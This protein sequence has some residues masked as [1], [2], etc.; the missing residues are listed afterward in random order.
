MIPIVFPHKLSKNYSFYIYLIK[1]HVQQNII[2]MRNKNNVFVNYMFGPWYAG[3]LVTMQTKTS[4][5]SPV[6]T[7]HHPSNQCG[8][9]G[10]VGLLWIE[11]V[12]EGG[13]GHIQ[14]WMIVWKIRYVLWN[15]GTLCLTQLKIVYRGT[16]SNIICVCLLGWGRRGL[17]C[18][19]PN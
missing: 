3:D 7:V 14:M 12:V 5:R 9:S 15:Y 16:R 2:L 4:L 11:F 10:S 19:L 13:A 6:Y 1:E 17:C 8:S 18:H